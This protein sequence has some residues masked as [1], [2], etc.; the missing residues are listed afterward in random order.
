MSPILCFGLAGCHAL[1]PLPGQLCIAGPSFFL[2][3]LFLWFPHIPPFAISVSLFLF[4][5]LLTVLLQNA[6]KHRSRMAVT[7]SFVIVIPF[8][9]PVGR[10]AFL[11]CLYRGHQT[12]TVPQNRRMF[13]LL[14]IDRSLTPVSR[15]HL[16]HIIKTFIQLKN[17]SLQRFS[18]LIIIFSQ[19]H[20]VVPIHIFFMAVDL[21]MQLPAFLYQFPL[22]RSA[23][24]RAS[25]H[26]CQ[27][28]PNS[29]LVVFQGMDFAA[30]GMGPCALHTFPHLQRLAVA[31]IRGSKSP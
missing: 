25:R 22:S 20:K 7:E 15:L 30:C 23:V 29:P 6:A 31:L 8:F 4:S 28:H 24:V 5:F 2:W 1:Q 13:Q 3:F 19:L 10:M 9:Q 16:I 26:I 11:V 27:L 21:K 18:R 17:G 14:F 12:K